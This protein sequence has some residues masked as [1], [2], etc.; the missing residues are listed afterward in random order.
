MIPFVFACDHCGE[1]AYSSGYND[2]KPDEEAIIEWYRPEY[3][4]IK[5]LRRK[6]S[7]DLEHVLDG[8]LMFRY[9]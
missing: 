3:S 8:G 7:R 9:I 2:L 6:G 5:K 1:I 4:E